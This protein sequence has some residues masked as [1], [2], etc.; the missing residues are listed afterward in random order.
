MKG[1]N[2]AAAL[3]KGDRGSQEVIIEIDGKEFK[4]ESVESNIATD[5][6]VIVA[7]KS[8]PLVAKV[9]EKKTKTKAKK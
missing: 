5:C 8:K 3:S 1:S 6:T 7:V 4:V 9:K 2:L